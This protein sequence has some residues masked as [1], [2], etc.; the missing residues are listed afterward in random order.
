VVGASPKAIQMVQTGFNL[1][2]PARG[3]VS[4]SNVPVKEQSKEIYSVYK[5][6]NQTAAAPKTEAVPE[7]AVKTKDITVGV[8]KES[9]QNEKRVSITPENVKQ[10][11]KAGYKAVL[12]E[13]G[14]GEGAK[15]SD[16]DY[17]NAGATIVSNTEAFQADIVLKVRGPLPIQ[18]GKNEVDLLKPTGHLISLL[19]PGINPP[20]VEA[21]QKKNVT[22]FAMDCIPRISRAQVF[23]AL[24][25][26]ANISGYKAVIEAA[27][28][29]GRFFPG[30]ITAAGKVPP[31]KLLVIGVGVAGLAAIQT[32]KTLGAVVRAFDTRPETK[33]QVVS[34]GGEFLEVSMK[35]DGSGQGGYAKE[36]SPEFI[37]AEMALFH[38]QAKEVDIIITT[39]AI[40][41]K[42]APKLI[43]KE[44][45]L[46]MKAGSVIVDL[47]AETGGNCELTK[48][49][50]VYRTENGV[51]VVG[52]YDFPSRLPTQSSTLYGNNVTKFLLSM[53]N[54]KG[55]TLILI[56]KTKLF[57]VLLY[58]RKVPNYGLLLLLLLLL[59]SLNLKKLLP[60]KLKKIHS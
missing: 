6:Y 18:N 49:G 20:V 2:V 41:G 29:F 46:A 53:T 4:V 60:L 59:H 45:V 47:A 40:P 31:A 57:V 11:L 56:L 48:P 39:A 28:H 30:Q 19:F 23:D 27:H 8:P 9:F 51:T 3:F 38:K 32:A 44:H 35:E 10:L 25:S 34:V 55:D 33:E 5:R 13:K 42:P 58:V 17:V 7:T 43:K 16:G 52:L 15:F 24:S 12:V 1:I 26:M 21:L 22:S 37:A 36:M 50:E 54:T 14:A